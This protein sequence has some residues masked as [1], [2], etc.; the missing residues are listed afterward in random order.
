MSSSSRLRGLY[1]NFLRDGFFVG[2]FKLVGFK[3]LVGRIPFLHDQFL[4]FQNFVEDSHVRSTSSAT[5]ILSHSCLLVFRIGIAI[6][7]V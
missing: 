7:R 4:D 1:R 3:V 5:Q 6:C 2:W